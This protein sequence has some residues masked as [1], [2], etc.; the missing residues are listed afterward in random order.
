M[1]R[2]KQKQTSSNALNIIITIIVAII[3]IGVGILLFRQFKFTP[4][5]TNEV[6]NKVK[7]TASSIKSNSKTLNNSVLV[8]LSEKGKTLNTLSSNTK[9]YYNNINNKIVIAEEQIKIT[10]KESAKGINTN[11]DSTREEL[12]TNIDSTRKELNTNID[13]TRKELNTNIDSTREELNTNIDSTRE[14]ILTEINEVSTLMKDRF[15]SVDDSLNTLSDDLMNDTNFI[16]S[17]ISTKS[18]EIQTSLNAVEKNLSSVMTNVES[19]L[20]GVSINIESNLAKLIETKHD[21]LTKDITAISTKV[22]TSLDT[23]DEETLFGKTALLLEKIENVKTTIDN[24]YDN[25]V[26]ANNKLDTV[27]ANTNIKSLDETAINYITNKCQEYKDSTDEN[28]SSIIT[29]LVTWLK[30]NN[31]TK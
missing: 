21:S 16:I 2:V 27:L 23:K 29:E 10:L 9:K 30:E 31:Y 8:D 7:T 11:I 4:K 17:S 12:N 24:V 15:D 19:N 1:E 18:S 6:L 13:S 26:S 22:G 5:S 14:E 25:T 20:S 3:L 28:K